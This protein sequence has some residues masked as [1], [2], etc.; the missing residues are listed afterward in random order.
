M[1]PVLECA[2]CAVIVFLTGTLLFAA[3]VACVAIHEGVRAIVQATHRTPESAPR[4]LPRLAIFALRKAGTWAH[5]E[6]FV[7]LR[8][9]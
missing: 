4:A 8:D 3:S 9:T 7:S 2:V 5:A 6:A 1:Y